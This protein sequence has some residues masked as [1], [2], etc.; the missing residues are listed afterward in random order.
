MDFKA[1]F[2]KYIKKRK[3][4]RRK[5]YFYTK[6]TFKNK[7]HLRLIIIR[8]VKLHFLNSKNIK[9]NSH[10]IF[11]SSYPFSG[12]LI[13]YSICIIIMNQS[14]NSVCILISKPKKCQDRQ[15]KYYKKIQRKSSTPEILHIIELGIFR[16]F[17]PKN[18]F[19]F[20]FQVILMLFKL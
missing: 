8:K 14:I 4:I 19:K 15:K 12:C 11:Y 10:S 1:Y 3:I 5:T 2:K 16:Y 18:I 17:S 6:R 9:S 20:L 13:K 7:L